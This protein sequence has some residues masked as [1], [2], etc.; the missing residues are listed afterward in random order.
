MRESEYIR[1]VHTLLPASFYHL[2]LN[3]PYTAGVP[4]C[5]YSGSRADLWV[6]WKYFKTIPREVDLCSGKNPVLTRLQQDW[7][8]CR[9]AERRKVAVIVGTCKGC[10]IYPD[11]SWQHVLTRAV[12]IDMIRSK[13][14]TALWIER[15]CAPVYAATEMPPVAESIALAGNARA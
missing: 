15:L 14:Y 9:H 7:L 13:Q 12:F 5:Y 3:L 2:K 4:D 11:L 6:E 1:T 10:V 8:A